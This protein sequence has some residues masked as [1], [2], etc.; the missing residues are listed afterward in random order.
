MNKADV[1][2]Y[3]NDGANVRGSLDESQIYEISTMVGKLMLKGGKL[4]LMGNGGSA[5]DA[6]HIAA[7]FMC[8]FE[9]ERKPLFAIALHTDTSIITA[10]AN[11]Y[12]YDKIF[13]RQIEAM[14]KP[15]DVVIGISTSGNSPNVLMAL[16]RANKIGCTTIALTGK[17]GGKM[18]E[19]AKYVINVGSDRTSIVQECHIAIG[20]IM[21][22]VIEDMV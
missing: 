16:E 21:S 11:D 22:K 14:G 20:H 5:A 17:K 12:G 3:L 9:K 10:I 4:I 6:Q 2:K 8:R 13:E 18:A 19:Y 7:E 1:R 15:G